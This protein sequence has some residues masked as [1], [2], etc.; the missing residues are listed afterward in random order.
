MKIWAHKHDIHPDFNLLRLVSFVVPHWLKPT[1]NRINRFTYRQTKMAKNVET[2]KHKIKGYQD[3]EIAL[4]VYQIKDTPSNAPC[5]IAFHGGGFWA[6]ALANYKVMYNQ[7]VLGTGAKLVFVDYTLALDAPYPAAVED[8]YQTAIWVYENAEPL[9][10]NK[11]KIVLTGES[12]GGTLTAAVTQMLRDRNQFKPCFQIL[13]YPWTDDRLQTKSA[14][15]YRNVP[16]WNTKSSEDA[17]PLY[18]KGHQGQTPAYAF[19]NHA[20]DF[21][22]LPNAYIEIAEFDSLRDEA[23][24]YANHLNQAGVEVE[25]FEVKGAVHGFELITWSEIT[26]AA[27]QRRINVINGVFTQ[28]L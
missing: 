18:L 16:I 4:E 8:C 1:V 21:A 6:Y 11:H 28:F 17:I 3:K 13:L 25:L 19:P 9:G 14:K 27:I 2:V 22:N 7:Y 10:I 26:K 23:V 5:I 20:T 24:E 12:A 15:K